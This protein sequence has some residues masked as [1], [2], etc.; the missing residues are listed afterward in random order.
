MP[1]FVGKFRA[2]KRP[3]QILGE[4]NANDSRTEHEHVDIVVLDALVR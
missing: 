2:H 1:L 4:G 3:Y